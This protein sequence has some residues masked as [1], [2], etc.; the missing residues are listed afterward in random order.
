MP[1]FHQR[2]RAARKAAGMT[3]EQ[4][5]FQIGVTK[6]SVSAWET[7]RETPSF[8]LLPLLREVLGRSLDELICGIGEDGVREGEP[9]PAYLDRARSEDERRFLLRFRRL[10][11]ARRQAVLVLMPPDEG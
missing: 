5:G 1:D 6:A 10:D 8:R 2:L 7:G 11:A 3:Q 9:E 4:L